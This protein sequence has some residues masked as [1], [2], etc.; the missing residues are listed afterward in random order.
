MQVIWQ[1][2]IMFELK[3]IKWDEYPAMQKNGPL[4][5]VTS[6]LDQYCFC[7]EFSWDSWYSGFEEWFSLCSPHFSLFYFSI[8]CLLTFNIGNY[9]IGS[10]YSKI[11]IVKPNFSPPCIRVEVKRL[12]LLTPRFNPKLIIVFTEAAQIYT[13]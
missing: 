3:V 9:F 11:L 13:P 8:P 6:F 4:H 1:E 2:D 5:Q 10:K 12:K 7:N